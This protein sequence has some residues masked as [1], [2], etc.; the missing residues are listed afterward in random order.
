MKGK[1]QNVGITYQ[2][3]A[4]KRLR[5]ISIVVDWDGRAPDIDRD[6]LMG[7]INRLFADETDAEF[8]ARGVHHYGDEEIDSIDMEQGFPYRSGSV[9]F[10][11]AQANAGTGRGARV[12][13]LAGYRCD[14]DRRERALTAVVNQRQAIRRKRAIDAAQDATIL[15]IAKTKLMGQVDTEQ[16]PVT[17]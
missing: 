16:K 2:W 15:G 11:T 9:Q 4:D 3:D 1:V 6:T 17:K 14:P 5:A 13:D 12:S 8:S 10:V 7:R